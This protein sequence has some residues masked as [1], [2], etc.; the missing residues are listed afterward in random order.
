L[1]TITFKNND[2]KIAVDEFLRNNP[3]II[4]KRQN[5]EH[6]SRPTIK[7][8]IEHNKKELGLDY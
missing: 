4:T 6:V 8:Y 2:T 1:I 5:Y 7:K 3:E